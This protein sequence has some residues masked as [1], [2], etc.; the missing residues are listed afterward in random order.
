MLL[1]CLWIHREPE[2]QSAI[3][4]HHLVHHTLLHVWFEVRP[5]TTPCLLAYHDVWC[6]TI[7]WP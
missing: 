3:R 5:R 4:A 7:S 2:G 1:G 6:C